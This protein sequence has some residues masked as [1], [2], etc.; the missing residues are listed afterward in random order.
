MAGYNPWLPDSCAGRAPTS[1]HWCQL[2]SV[3]QHSMLAK[4]ASL[5]CAMPRAVA[6]ALLSRVLGLE[7]IQTRIPCGHMTFGRVKTLAH[8]SS[9][10]GLLLADHSSE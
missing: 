9:T 8:C 2:G 6:E 5:Y 3:S 1:E 10:R 7:N 4:G